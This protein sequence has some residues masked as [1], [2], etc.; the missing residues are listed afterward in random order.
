MKKGLIVVG[1]CVFL[2]IMTDTAFSRQFGIGIGVS[3]NV[4][5]NSNSNNSNNFDATMTPVSAYLI[6][7]TPL[8]RFE[9]ELGY[10]DNKVGHSDYKDY[11]QSQSITNFG[12][13]LFYNRNTEN[14]SFYIGARSGF[15]YILNIT[16]LP[17]AN[18]KD[19]YERKD[20]FLAPAFG[21]EYVFNTVFSLGGEMQV[22][23]I[24]KGH[25]K[26]DNMNKYQLSETRTRTIFFARY[27]F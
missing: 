3:T 27:Y 26:D 5:Y 25:E 21:F 8:L 24:W 15:T 10:I 11:E 12:F 19:E 18:I 16:N 9:T 23:T 7:K 6:Y 4:T 17:W 1:I 20:F 2:T 13:G 22:F 14:S